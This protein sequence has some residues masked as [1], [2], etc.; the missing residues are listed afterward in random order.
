MTGRSKSSIYSGGWTE[1]TPEQ[2]S[3]CRLWRSVITQSISD[4]SKSD[5]RRRQEV[6]DWVGSK[7]FVLVCNLA[8]VNPEDVQLRFKE[9]LKQE[10]PA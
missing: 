9:F 2:L 4:L 8:L 10:L 3:E 1:A 5:V 6:I 7:D